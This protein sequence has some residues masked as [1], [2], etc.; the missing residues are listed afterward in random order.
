MVP[1]RR[2]PL[3]VV[4]GASCVGKSTACEILFQQETDYVVLESDVI[5]NDVYNTP[6][7]DYRAYRAVQLNLCANIAQAGKPVVLCGCA[8]PQQLESLPGRKL[9]TAIHYIAIVCGDEAMEHRLRKGRKIKDQ[10][11]L[12]SS[13]HFNQ[14]LKE[15][16][17]VTNPPME[18][19]DN[20]Q[21][22]PGETAALIDAW[23][24]KHL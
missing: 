15:H 2:L 17:G 4:S 13:L 12:R 8:T 16:A 9:F 21:R 19:L 7:D 23:I 14:W 5:W 24:Q 11:H 18:L 1:T 6:D 10:A 3:F 22:T 20:S